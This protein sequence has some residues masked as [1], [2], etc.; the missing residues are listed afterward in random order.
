MVFL[1]LENIYKTTVVNETL[2]KI[3]KSIIIM[4]IFYKMSEK[5]P[6]VLYRY[7]MELNIAG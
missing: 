4:V 1:C 3:L 5:C 6:T 2:L 7:F